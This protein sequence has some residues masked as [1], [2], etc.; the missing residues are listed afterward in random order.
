M[1]AKLCLFIVNYI[2]IYYYYIYQFD[3]I[4]KS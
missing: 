3:E 1:N 4:K 2:I